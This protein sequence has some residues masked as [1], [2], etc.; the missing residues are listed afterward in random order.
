MSLQ[1]P[2]LFP[3]GED[4]YHPELLLTGAGSKTNGQTVKK[5]R[6]RMSATQYYCF[7]LQQRR[8]EPNRL[9]MGGRLLHQL[10][11]DAYT[12]VE[13]SR[14]TYHR[15]HQHILRSE[16]YQGLRDAFARGDTLKR[17]GRRIILP[18]SFTGGPRYMQ[19]NYQDAMAIC[20]AFG[21]PD[22]F[23]TFTCNAKW[24]EFDEAL[25]HIP[26]KKIEDRPD[27]IARVFKMKLD[28]LMRYLKNG[29]YFGAV[30]AALYTVE[31]QKCGLPMHI[32]SFG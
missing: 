30:D 26:G 9:L 10:V 6:D 3:Y 28:A 13:Q 2:L 27:L 1:Y 32:L 24:R 12:S 25:K 8:H 16:L 11:V 20:R 4:G 19:Q 7:R 22:L 15:T 5:K 18:S 23:L 29:K 17:V 21:H 14:L 31:F